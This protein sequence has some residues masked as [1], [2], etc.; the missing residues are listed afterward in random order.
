MSNV[1]A[2]RGYIVARGSSAAQRIGDGSNG[3]RAGL[4]KKTIA[5]WSCS[6]YVIVP[7]RPCS[8]GGRRCRINTL[9]LSVLGVEPTRTETK[10][11][12]TGGKEAR[13]AGTQ[14]DTAK[15]WP[16]SSSFCES[17]PDHNR[18]VFVFTYCN[19][20][21]QLRCSFPVSN[22]R[23]VKALRRGSLCGTYKSINS[24]FFIIKNELL[25]LLTPK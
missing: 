15:F 18:F 1:H 17:S 6:V 11:R 8:A 20:V 25:L 7:N 13:Q 16:L 12:G 2:N 14:R 22:C 19:R 5:S 21:W 4:G 23:T 9:A 24:F 10:E 3:W